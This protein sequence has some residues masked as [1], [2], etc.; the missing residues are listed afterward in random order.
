MTTISEI[1]KSAETLVKA[2]RLWRDKAAR[3]RFEEE[4]GLEPIISGGGLDVEAQHQAG[5][6][7]RYHREFMEWSAKQT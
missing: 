6:T 1:E 7:E 3:T 2:N 5:R 4:V